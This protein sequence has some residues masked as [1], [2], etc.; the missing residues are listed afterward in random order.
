VSLSYFQPAEFD[1]NQTLCSGDSLLVGG[2]WYHEG[3]PAGTVVLP[4]GAANGCDS[5]I[6]VELNFNPIAETDLATTLCPGAS[7]TVN[8]S[9]YNA[10][11]PTGTAIIPGGSALGCDSVVH[12]SLSFYQ[13]AVFLLSQTL[14]TGGSLIVNGS[15]YDESQPNGTETIPAA[16]AT[17]CDSVIVIDLSFV[18]AVEENIVQTLCPGESIEVGGN[19]YDE[20]IPSGTELFPGGSY[21][22]CD[23]VVNV[24][25]SFYPVALFSLEQTYCEG[26]SLVVNGTVYDEN[27]P[28]GVEI[29]PG[30]SANGC[31][32]TIIVDL[33]FNADATQ[34]LVQTLCQGESLLVG[35]TVYD[36]DNPSGTTIL[37]GSSFLGCDSVVTVS[38]SFYPPA[39]LDLSQTLCSGNS[40]TVNG[41]EYDQSNPSGI[42]I[43]PG[44]GT[45]GCD[46]V[47]TV[48]L[49]FYNPA[50]SN[51]S[52]KLC[53]GEE[54]IVA[55]TLFSSADPSG[56]V[57]IS[58]GSFQGCDSTVFVNLSYYPQAIGYVSATL[59]S[60]QSLTVNG[61]VYDEQNPAGAEVLPGASYTGCDSLVQVQLLFIKTLSA[62]YTLNSPACQNGTDGSLV[63]DTIDGGLPP[64]IVQLSGFAPILVDT[65]PLVFDNLSVGFYQLRLEDADGVEATEDLVLDNP[66]ALVLSAGADQT[67]D[68]G[69]STSLSATV[70]FAV[71]S[72]SWS[73]A[74]YLSCLDCP[75]PEV[76]L[77]ATDITYT[78]TAIS[79]DGCSVSDEVSITV[80]KSRNIFVPNAFSPNND[81]INDFVTVFTG[82]NVSRVRSFQVFDRWG[83]HLFQVADLKPNDSS[84][85][86]DG[87]FRGE[88]M[89]AGVY[90]WFA[91]VEF[92]DGEV[93]VL[94]GD[95]MLV[96]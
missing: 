39:A 20:D 48:S 79:A 37:Q 63:I 69:L 15:I 56:S 70:S 78:L 92:V 33:S 82:P 25:L 10:A 12:V 32:S 40:L 57:V 90:A 2:T 68:L 29:L 44:G 46:S 83:N 51:V 85:G 96:R 88:L 24:S 28:S 77:P 6:H 8:G 41:T 26:E 73:P 50:S 89:D 3:L 4:A 35:N 18:D 36:E 52:A 54:L 71:D 23:S 81:G 67:V 13:P 87:K 94:E 16:A 9:A 53:Q 19:T 55:G 7:L 59:E 86:W 58:G 1:L 95:V 84:G 38:L 27:H 75:D 21:L 62:V 76:L 14:C 22:G 5:I 34:S 64:F 61:V 66:P 31:D 30:A 49:S 17:G 80:V 91:E 43:I 74:D 93:F 65:F 42:E 60:G 47:I 72:W 45:G 11:N